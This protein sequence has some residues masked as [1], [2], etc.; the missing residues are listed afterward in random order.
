[1]IPQL[2]N[3]FIWIDSRNFKRNCSFW[4]EGALKSRKPKLT[5]LAG[6]PLQ[7]TIVQSQ[8]KKKK[9]LEKGVPMKTPEIC[10]NLKLKTLEWRH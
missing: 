5:S 10:S 3:Y 4:K 2:L 9:E 7:V 6:I 8:Q 1:M